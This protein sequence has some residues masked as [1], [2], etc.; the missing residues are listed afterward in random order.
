MLHVCFAPSPCCCGIFM[1]IV[2][3]T[4]APRLLGVPLWHYKF[5]TVLRRGTQ[6]RTVF[7]DYRGLGVIVSWIFLKLLKLLQ[8]EACAAVLA[9]KLFFIEL[10][11]TKVVIEENHSE[12]AYKTAN[13]MHLVTE[14]HELL[15]NSPE[16]FK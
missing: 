6:S 1:Q 7:P 11:Q 14:Y 2:G 8:Q 5:H 15:L 16:S 13:K 9:S 12:I 4:V 3:S 10:A